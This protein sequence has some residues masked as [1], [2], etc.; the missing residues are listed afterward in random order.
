MKRTCVAG[1]LQAGTWANS[2]ELLTIIKITSVLPIGMT[3]FPDR[4][5]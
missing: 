3:I 2:N 5:D 1:L 4:S